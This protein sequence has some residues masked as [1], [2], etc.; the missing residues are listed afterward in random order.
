MLYQTA[1]SKPMHIAYPK[2]IS[3]HSFS[4]TWFALQ[5]TSVLIKCLIV[6]GQG[7]SKLTFSDALWRHAR[8]LSNT[9][10]VQMVVDAIGSWDDDVTYHMI[11][12]SRDSKPWASFC[13]RLWKLRC[14]VNTS[15]KMAAVLHTPLSDAILENKMFWILNKISLKYFMCLMDKT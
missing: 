12:T 2:N 15:N 14:Q 5:S 11:S 10:V 4:E 7:P 8:V 1:S 9:A 6:L 13:C 3:R